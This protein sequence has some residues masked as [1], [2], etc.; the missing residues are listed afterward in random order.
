MSFGEGILFER[1]RYVRRLAK[2]RDIMGDD[3]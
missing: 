3:A 2:G 1:P